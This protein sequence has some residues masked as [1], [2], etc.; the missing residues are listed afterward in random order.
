MRPGR[1]E[2]VASS[3][4]SRALQRGRAPPAA[5]ACAG[6]RAQ[7][8]LRLQTSGGKVGAPGNLGSAAPPAR[9][10]RQ[11]GAEIEL[12]LDTQGSPRVSV[13]TGAPGD[14]QRVSDGYSGVLLKP[15]GGQGK[16]ARSQNLL[17]KEG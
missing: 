11:V 7:S 2:P 4:G 10:D 1:V 6:D 13:P 15:C 8:W 16:G 9:R 17:Q 5:G 12:A 14:W 3:H